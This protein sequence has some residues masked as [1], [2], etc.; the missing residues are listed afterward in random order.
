MISGKRLT[1]RHKG[2]MIYKVRPKQC[3]ETID[4]T[5]KSDWQFEGEGR[6]RTYR[7][8]RRLGKSC[9][10]VN[11]PPSNPNLIT[12]STWDEGRTKNERMGVKHAYLKWDCIQQSKGG[13]DK[14][15]RSHAHLP[16]IKA[17][18]GLTQHSK[19][20][21][22]LCRCSASG[23]GALTQ[24]GAGWPAAMNGEVNDEQ[25][26]DIKVAKYF[27]AD[28]VCLDR[29]L[30]GAGPVLSGGLC[31]SFASGSHGYC[32]VSRWCPP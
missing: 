30:F 11:K 7:C 17:S 19:L 14:S 25:S 22:D 5:Y 12:V 29:R 23:L 15:S 10:S 28:F 31:N 21:W 18:L 1:V 24:L 27:T 4:I 26:G 8:K 20:S 2:N 9:I 3:E 16:P 13:G 6:D 32:S